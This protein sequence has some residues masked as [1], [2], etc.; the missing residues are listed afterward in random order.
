MVSEPVVVTVLPANDAC[1]LNIV[2][3]ECIVLMG[4]MEKIIAFYS[5]MCYHIR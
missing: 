1:A 5:Q 4:E 2:A 3:V